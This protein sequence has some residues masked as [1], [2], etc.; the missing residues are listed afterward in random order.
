MDGKNRGKTT[1]KKSIFPTFGH[2]TAQK[3]RKKPQM[4]TTYRKNHYLCENSHHKNAH[5]YES[6]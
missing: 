6:H 5:F 3:E 4:P 2:E 1:K